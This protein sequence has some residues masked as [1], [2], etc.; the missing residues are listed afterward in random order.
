MIKKYHGKRY[1]TTVKKPG[2]VTIICA[3]MDSFPAL[4]DEEF[5]IEFDDEM[6]L[7]VIYSEAKLESFRNEKYRAWQKILVYA[8]ALRKRS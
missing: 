5:Y 8:Q 3:F 7:W 4:K 6:N 2:D 1:Y